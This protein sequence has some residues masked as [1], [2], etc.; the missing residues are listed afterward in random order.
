MCNNDYRKLQLNT[1]KSSNRFE[2][3]ARN[4]KETAPINEREGHRGERR[5]GVKGQGTGG[6]EGAGNERGSKKTSEED[7]RVWVTLQGTA[8]VS[9]PITFGPELLAVA[10]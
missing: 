4:L 9:E 5:E 7:L 2:D 1:V 3:T 10:D 6:C 8:S